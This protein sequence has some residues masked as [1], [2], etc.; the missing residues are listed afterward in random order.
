MTVR[1]WFRFFWRSVFFA[2]VAFLPAFGDEII[3]DNTSN[4]L[5][6]YAGEQR[7][8]GDQLDLEG[9]ARTLTE[10]DFEYFADIAPDGTQ[11]MKVRLY[12]N[13]VPYDN[14][15]NRPTELL[16]ESGFLPLIK[17]YGTRK[18]TGLDV[19]LPRDTVTFTVEFLGL[20][21]NE[22]GGLLFYSPPTVGFSFNEFWRRTATGGW[23]VVRYSTT[24]PTQRA[25][26]S[27]RLTAR[28]E[29]VL[30]ESRTN[31]SSEISLRDRHT[32]LRAAQTFIPKTSG[33]LDH[34]TTA[35]Y[36]AGAP[37]Q[38]R[39]LDTLDGAPGTNVLGSVR[40]IQSGAETTPVNFYDAGVY[41]TAGETYAAEFSTE[42]GFTDDSNYTLRTVENRINSESLWIRNEAESPWRKVTQNNDGVT[43][44]CAVLET[45]IV[46]GGPFVRI[47]SPISNQ[48]FQAPQ[49]V[50]IQPLFE[51]P[52]GKTAAR[53]KLMVNG[54]PV[55]TNN[56]PP[57]EF[58]WTNA[59]P[60]NYNL[61]AIV[62]DLLNEPFRSD[63]TPIIVQGSDVPAN[64]DFGGRVALNGNYLRAT[65]SSAGATLEPGETL[66]S[67]N[68]SGATLWWSWTAASD[69]P[70]T[71]SAQNTDG[72]AAVA[73]FTGNI[74]ESLVPVTNGIPGCRFV[75]NS[76]TSYAIAV[77]P[78]K[79]GANVVLDIAVSDF[80]VNLSKTSSP[81]PA[82]ISLAA[83]GS[84]ERQIVKVEF[85][86]NN[87]LLREFTNA[88]YTFDQDFPLVGQYAITIAATDSRGIRTISLPQQL[89][90]LPATSNVD[91]NLSLFRVIDG[92]MS[93]LFDAPANIPVT[94]EYSDDLKT[95]HSGADPVIGSGARV[96]WRDDG[97]PKTE[98]HPRNTP[99]RFYRLRIDL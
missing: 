62:E 65:A 54:Q 44:M 91:A 33:R 87:T 27:V 99:R 28:G 77:D 20:K 94:I 60:G 67:T 36:W 42:E 26:A 45:W 57:F 2:A 22:S 79:R 14:F 81:A 78:L 9:T 69:A 23:E 46:P 38:V 15:R 24:D 51:L 56:A 43:G 76:G 72:S 32:R 12:S 5:G 90:V 6:H 97:P 82:H 66:I 59:A 10:L 16:Y 63:V 85:F 21:T 11:G 25:N 35:L 8:F 93:V 71:I 34:L 80:T 40:V 68:S 53:A 1:F 75:P 52:A 37:V 86:S 13:E 89:S 41:L 47:A 96:A 70:V 95:W 84:S 39:I 29:A 18:I 83:D 7:E 31:W 49:P 48:K 92:S 19:R 17:G 50:R 61:R 3:Y 74:L 55:F 98:S 30:D 64:D 58:V 4:S 88:P 73:V